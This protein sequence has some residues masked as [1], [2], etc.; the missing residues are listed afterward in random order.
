MLCTYVRHIKDEYTA[1]K[2][3][4]PQ[5]LVHDNVVAVAELIAFFMLS[6]GNKIVTFPRVGVASKN[7]NLSVIVNE[8]S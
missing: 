7:I 2:T 6:R 1:I 4:F 3:L 8:K 5:R